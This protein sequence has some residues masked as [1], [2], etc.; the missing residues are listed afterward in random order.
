MRL[1]LWAQR[2]EVRLWRTR[3]VDA[4]FCWVIPAEND[5]GLARLICRVI[6]HQVPAGCRL[7]LRG[8]ATLG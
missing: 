4:V 7:L 8:S 6:R 3:H 5:S 1:A 2:E